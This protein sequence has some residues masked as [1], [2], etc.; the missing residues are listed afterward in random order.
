MVCAKGL[1]Q[2][3]ELRIGRRDA[4]VVLGEISLVVEDDPLVN[5][6]K[7]TVDLAVIRFSLHRGTVEIF[8]PWLTV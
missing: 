4:D 7:D 8:E 5:A 3:H 2:G 1:E 6:R